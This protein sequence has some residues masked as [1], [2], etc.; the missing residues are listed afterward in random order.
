[1]S[2][3]PGLTQSDLVVIDKVIEDNNFVKDSFSKKDLLKI[4]HLYKK[5]KVK[6]KDEKRYSNKREFK[7]FVRYC[8]SRNI[9]NF[10][11]MILTTGVKGGGKSSTA[12]TLAREWCKLLGIN[13]KPERHMAYNNAEV[14]EKIQTLNPFEP[15]ICDEAIR[16]ASAED[17]NKKENKE[18]KKVL[19]QVRTKHLF[20]ILC[21]PLQI[22]KLQKEYLDSYVNY[23][24]DLYDRGVGALY[25]PDR[26][27]SKDAWNMT[28]FNKMGVINEFSNPDMVE[29]KL[30][31]HPNYWQTLIIPKVPDK[32]YNNYLQVRERNVYNDKN[33][34]DAM[35]KD[36]IHK[37]ALLLM[38]KE[39]VT[40]DSSISYDRIVKSI[41]R[42]FKL[43]IPK[44]QLYAIMND[45]QNLVNTYINNGGDDNE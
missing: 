40:K 1:M 22:Q 44:Q 21:F 37:A 2:L 31:T 36:D 12:I 41:E 28:A 38:L 19:G 32:I 11:T 29:K 4:L 30:S 20:Y 26:N 6:G 42:I 34:M 43:S 25:V 3:V 10:D 39:I 18:L 7:K 16:F 23:W 35:T 13:F 45:A 15:L 17:W 5:V 8:L 9:R 33:V 27:P 24:I 14:L